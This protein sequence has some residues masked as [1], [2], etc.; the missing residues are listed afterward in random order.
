[1]K[2]ERNVKR[3]HWTSGSGRRKSA[4]GSSYRRL[5][6][7]QQL[8]SDWTQLRCEANMIAR[9]EP[10]LADQV[11]NLILRHGSF[12]DALAGLVGSK[13]KDEA[14]PAE[15]LARLAREAIAA[16]PAIAEA[17]LADLRAVRE[18]D[19]AAGRLITPFLHFKGYQGLQAYRIAHWLWHEG[20][21]ELARH[22]QSRIS[23]CFAIDIHPA[24]RIGSGILI[25]HG[26]GVVIGETAVVEDDVSMLHGV[27]LG[28]T[29]KERGDR[30]PKVHSGVLLGAGAKILGNIVIG[31]GSK[32]GAGSVVLQDV[33]PR[34][35]VVGVP[36]RVVSR[37]SGNPAHG[38]DHRLSDGRGSDQ[39]H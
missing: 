2:T 36:A 32:V 21:A 28:G 23:E 13:L 6:D 14:T 18:R 22:L 29:G 19:P 9:H 39:G 20:R 12:A 38:M 8:T 34:S 3:M 27:T 10:L 33:P 26:H 37:C 1:M 31:A 15:V 16:D 5:T 35:T 25:D 17:A 30:H 11:L 4:E 24:A 7:C